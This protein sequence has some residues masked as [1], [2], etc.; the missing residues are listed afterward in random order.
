[1]IL[2][3]YVK[4]VQNVTSGEI[5]ES[6]IQSSIILVLC[7]LKTNMSF[8][9][10]AVLFSM[11]ISTCKRNFYKYVSYLSASIKPA[12]YWPSKEEIR[13]NLPL[14]FKDF[15]DT[16]IIL[17]ATEIKVQKLNCLK[18]RILSYSHYKCCHT[19]KFLIGITPSG[20]IS[21]VS[22]AYGGRS[23]DRAIFCNENI[24]TKLDLHDA[25][26]VDKGILI[27]KE[28][29]ENCIKLIRPPFLRKNI[30][31]SKEQALTTANIARA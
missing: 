1:M 13:K 2:N 18:C 5:S 20:L 28:C 31:F 8:V 9:C 21:Y 24:I 30:Q 11:N 15:K 10:L 19:M 6:E 7:K 4:C 26:M 3:A 22:K 17:D 23:S 16:S 14:C 27:E 25:I 12:I 29:E